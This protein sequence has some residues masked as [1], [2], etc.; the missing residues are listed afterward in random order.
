M[1]LRAYKAD[2]GRIAECLAHPDVDLEIAATAG[3][4][5]K[6]SADVYHDLEAYFPIQWHRAKGRQVNGTPGAE[7]N[8]R[9]P[10]RS[11][12]RRA[13]FRCLAEIQARPIHWL[14][15]G[16]FARGK[17]AMLAGNPG[18][19][20]SQVTASMAAIVST[21]GRWPVDRVACEAGNAVFLSA[22][23][24]P[25][26]TIRPRLEAAGADLARVF[27]L[28]AVV[29]GFNADGTETR[30]S[31]NLKT[32]LANLGD[33]LEEIGGA[34]LIVIDP[35]TAYLGDADSHK[36]AEIR[37]L[38]A[39]L[40]DLAAA[41]GAAIV[42]VSHMNKSS[43]GGGALMRVTGSLAF[44]AAAR[45]AYVVAKDSEDEARRLF[46]PL[47]NNI[48]TD[49]GGLAFT[50][51]PADVASPAGTIETSCVVWEAA[52][53]SVTA[54]EAMQPTEDGDGN[55]IG[56]AKGFLVDLLAS[57]PVPSKQVRAEATEAGLSWATVRRAQK[58]LGIK[59]EKQGGFFGG[60]A[61][62]QKWVWTLP[63]GLK[64]LKNPEGAHTKD[65][66]AFSEIEHLQDE[67]EGGETFQELDL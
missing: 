58:A 23:D 3:R 66:S 43:A 4:H 39:P 45:A 61:E 21:G 57:G 13:D 59:A 16:R 24:D 2:L 35:V 65:L 37:A 55:T 10:E 34:A 50:I 44:V 22:E 5:D 14:W 60:Q 27:I 20:K 56:D 62:S 31:F 41:H 26:D 38:L 40:S 1:S 51:E 7:T 6:T 17:V 54:D 46:L 53:I 11:P 32:D 12:A 15:P 36:N 18:L 9:A 49:Q 8:R 33:M 30:R 47:K 48:G 25:E 64:V 29:D 67:K 42:A 63:E 28:E 19:G 52:A